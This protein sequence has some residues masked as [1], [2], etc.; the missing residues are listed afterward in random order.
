M[1]TAAALNSTF[2]VAER[3]ARRELAAAFRLAAHFRRDRPGRTAIAAP[4][5]G[6]SL[7]PK[8]LGL[9]FEEITASSLMRMDLAGNVIEMP[10]GCGLNP[11]AFAVHSAV[12]SG[13]PDAM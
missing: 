1:A 9:L 6:G 5:A 3:Q 10:D 7:L 4:P 2:A 8:P 11:A 12:L 13:R